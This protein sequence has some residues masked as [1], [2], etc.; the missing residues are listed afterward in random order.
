METKF[1]IQFTL[2]TINGPESFAKFF[3]GNDRNNAF[4]IFSKLKGTDS[5]DEKNLLFIDF[6]ETKQGLPV[7]LNVIS[8]TL[9]QLGDNCRMVTKELFKA[10]NFNVA[11]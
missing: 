1:Y 7:N 5:V 8:C 3:I 11:G 4:E 2:K 10:V 9:D 6:M